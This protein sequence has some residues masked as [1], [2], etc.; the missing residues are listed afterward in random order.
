VIALPNDVHATELKALAEST[1]GSFVVAPEPEAIPQVCE[2]IYTG[3]ATQ[4]SKIVGFS[5]FIPNLKVFY[6]FR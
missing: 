5:F 6:T 3:C 2:A 1:G 4:K